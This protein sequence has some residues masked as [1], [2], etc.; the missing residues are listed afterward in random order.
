MA[1]KETRR[2]M[3]WLRLQQ[4]DFAEFRRLRVEG[5][6]VQGYWIFHP[7]Q[8]CIPIYRKP[9]SI[10]GFQNLVVQVF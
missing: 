3:A 1:G 5:L 7:M 4:L 8:F 6:K 9:R 2:L 10:K